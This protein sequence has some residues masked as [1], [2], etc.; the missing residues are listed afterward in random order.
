MAASSPFLHKLK[1]PVLVAHF[2]DDNVVEFA[3]TAA[4]Q[5]QAEK[6]NQKNMFFVTGP[7]KHGFENIAAE[8]KF[9]DRIVSFFNKYP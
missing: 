5:K 8:E 2:E 1:A 9:Y 6:L 4:L 7:G 3:Q